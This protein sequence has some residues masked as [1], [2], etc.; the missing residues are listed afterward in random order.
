MC[1]CVWLVF[2]SH[3]RNKGIFC[4]LYF[5]L[6]VTCPSILYG[7]GDWLA[8]GLLG[9]LRIPYTTLNWVPEGPEVT[10]QAD[11]CSMEASGPGFKVWFRVPVLISGMP[12][13]LFPWPFLIS[14]VVPVPFPGY[15]WREPGMC[16]VQRRSFSTVKVKSLSHRCH[17]AL[18]FNLNFITILLGDQRSLFH[19]E[20]SV[21]E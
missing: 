20:T 13:A 5:V 14:R 18:R 17:Q 3:N 9:L 21:L 15:P 16:N 6:D 7:I 12:S 8:I 19:L 11:S 4:S 1:V 2:L 10:W